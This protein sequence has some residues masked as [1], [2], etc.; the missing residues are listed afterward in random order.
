M[1][2]TLNKPVSL[3]EVDTEIVVVAGCA[4]GFVAMNQPPHVLHVDP[5]TEMASHG[6]QNDDLLVS[7]DG[8]STMNMTQSEVARQLRNGSRLEFERPKGPPE[9]DEDTDPPSGGEGRTAVPLGGGSLAVGTAGQAGGDADAKLP[10]S[11]PP[12]SAPAPAPVE[13]TAPAAPPEEQPKR[14]R[15][16]AGQIVGEAVPKGVAVAALSTV[17]ERAVAEPARAT[18]G[19][20]NACHRV[21]FLQSRHG[22]LLQAGV[23]HPLGVVVHH[24]MLA[25]V[26]RDHQDL[27]GLA[28]SHHHPGVVDGERTDLQTIG[29]DHMLWQVVGKVGASGLLKE[30]HLQGCGSIVVEPHGWNEMRMAV[31]VWWQ[32]ACPLVST[33]W[34]C[35]TSSSGSLGLCQRCG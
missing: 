23:H 31:G 9:G 21:A 12:A 29:A 17:V 35:S 3:E 28:N 26:C 7:I 2:V 34:M 1:Q 30:L 13:G 24:R 16:G 4:L 22:A 5:G 32:S 11:S 18:T 6:V 20:Q 25:M 10:L 19:M 27:L 8:V 15:V 33:T 14:L